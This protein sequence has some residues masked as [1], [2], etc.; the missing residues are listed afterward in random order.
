MIRPLAGPTLFFLSKRGLSSP[1][2]PAHSTVSTPTRARLH[3][4][5]NDY[6]LF[7]FIAIRTNLG[8]INIA[9]TGK[10]SGSKEIFPENTPENSSG[11]H[12]LP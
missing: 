8:Q 12:I 2:T 10:T 9:T 1:A 6:S 3:T 7:S 11:Q 4:V 5:L